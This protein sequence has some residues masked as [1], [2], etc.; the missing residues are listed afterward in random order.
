MDFQGYEYRF[1]F[2]Q[3]TDEGSSGGSAAGQARSKPIIQMHK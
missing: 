1:G 3:T 2:L